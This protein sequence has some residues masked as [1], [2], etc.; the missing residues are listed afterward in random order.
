MFAA[1]AIVI[2]VNTL[3][4]RLL[5]KV[6]GL[7]LIIHTLGFFAIVIPLVYLSGRYI[8]LVMIFPALTET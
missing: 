7:I 5:P 4:A 2:F 8:K 1:L 6:E 3:A